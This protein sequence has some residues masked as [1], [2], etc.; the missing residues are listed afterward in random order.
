[1]NIRATTEIK[2]LLKFL[3]IGIACFAFVL[4]SVYDG[5]V[6]YPNQMP[7]AVAWE[8]LDAEVPNGPVA[9]ELWDRI[10]T[11]HGLNV[12]F[13]SGDAAQTDFTKRNLWKLIAVQNGW[14]S[15][16]PKHDETVEEVQHKINY[17]Y[18]MGGVGLIISLPCLIWFMRNR[19]TWIESTEDGLRSSWGQELKCS[20]IKTFDKRKWDKKGIGVL[21]YED[22]MGV[23]K[24]FILDD[25][26]YQRQPMD[27]IVA[28]VESQ[29]SVDQIT[30]GIPEAMSDPIDSAAQDS[31][32]DDAEPE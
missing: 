5:L 12:E 23:E 15:R 14:D 17:Q 3:L 18:L 16:T 6:K 25:L 4:W 19:G 21:Y 32:P 13:V 1:M 8:K 30:N 26:K 11:Q 7:R 27:Q 20:Q 2:F 22:A 31:E 24:K 29:I 28:W 10:S 9:G